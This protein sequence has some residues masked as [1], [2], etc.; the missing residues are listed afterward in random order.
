M[1]ATTDLNVPAAQAAPPAIISEDWAAERPPPAP[2]HAPP[3]KK[4]ELADPRVKQAVADT[5]AAAPDKSSVPA[6]QQ[7]A[8]RAPALSA[9][10]YKKFS[11]DFAYA[12]V[13]YCLGNSALKFQPPTIGPIVF[14]GFLGIPFMLLAA[15]R[16]KCKV[17]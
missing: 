10:S 12:Q 13:P 3:A 8:L 4:L 7:E 2:P 14:G 1:Q 9:D 6:N 17:K 16:G 11:E 15:A 5:I